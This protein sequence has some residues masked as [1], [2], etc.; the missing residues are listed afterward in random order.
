MTRQSNVRTSQ[1]KHPGQRVPSYCDGFVDETAMTRLRHLVSPHIDSFNYFLQHGLRAAFEDL[2]SVDVKLDD[3]LYIKF[4]VVDADIGYPAT[5]DEN[6]EVQITPREARERGL[7]YSGTF[8][9][10]II[11]KINNIPTETMISSKMGDFPMMVMSDKCHIKDFSHQQ[12]LNAREESNEL[13]GYFIMN[14]LERVIRL[15]QVPRRNYATA[16]ERNSFKNRGPL[17]SDRGITMR[18]V[19]PDQ[20]SSTVTLHYLT[21]GGAT[22]R[23]VVRKQEFLLP[24]ILVA[25]AMT[26]NTVSDK[27]LFDRILQ[28]DTKN[29]FLAT[30]LEL[31]LREAHS[32]P[33]GSSAE[34]RAFLGTMF[35]QFLPV[36]DR[37]SDAVAGYTLINRYLF[38]HVRDAAA[39]LEALLHMMRKLYSFVQGNCE[40]DNYVK[41]KLEEMLL[42]VRSGLVKDYRMNKEKTLG[43]IQSSKYFQKI[44]DRFGSG[45]AN[46]IGTFISTGNLVSSTGL[47]LMQVSGYTIV[48][49]RLN[50]LRYMSHFQSVHR[51]QFFTTMK[52]TTVRK[53]LPESWGFMCPVHTPDGSP[54][55]L[56]NHLARYTAI[57]CFPTTIQLPSTAHGRISCTY[58]TSTT[59]TTT[60]AVGEWGQWAEGQ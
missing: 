29:T 7:S 53:L 8:R 18:C 40:A 32:L 35:R 39:K 60:G 36:S 33:I 28:G 4:N 34:A 12:L 30:R 51:G 37:T 6:G 24:V 42:N 47:D 21:N 25:K 17:Y 57:V 54:C 50:F 41:E 44:V 14:G 43:D 16:L 48:A 45:L 49:E 15:L 46:R 56:L 38:V 1:S 3:D 31:M 52:T 55:G 2:P 19:R 11:F 5:K 20:S 58:E 22:L 27:E 10:N 59:T 26:A 23:F 9:V 13:G